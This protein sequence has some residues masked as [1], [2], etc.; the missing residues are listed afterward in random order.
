MTS[1]PPGSYISVFLVFVILAFTVVEC[2]LQM[3]NEILKLMQER[4]ELNLR[5]PTWNN[6]GT[7]IGNQQ[8]HHFL[9][10]SLAYFED[11][12]TIDQSGS[13][14]RLITSPRYDTFLPDFHHGISDV[15]VYTSGI[16][17]RGRET[18][19]I[20]EYLRE[21]VVITSLLHTKISS[22]PHENTK[23]PIYRKISSVSTLADDILFITTSNENY[24][25]NDLF[26]IK[27]DLS[28]KQ[29]STNQIAP[30]HQRLMTREIGV[31]GIADTQQT[32]VKINYNDTTFSYKNETTLAGE[33]G[34]LTVRGYYSVGVSLYISFDSDARTTNK[35]QVGVNF[36]DGVLGVEFYYTSP[37][38]ANTRIFTA[39]TFPKELSSLVLGPVG[40]LFSATFDL[41]VQGQFN[42]NDEVIGF[43]KGLQS[44][45]E[46]NVLYNG[47]TNQIVTHSISNYNFTDSGQSTLVGVP[48]SASYYTIGMGPRVRVNISPGVGTASIS[49]S[50]YLTDV[51][52]G[53]ER[54]GSAFPLSHNLEY[55]MD[56]IA[57]SQLFSEE[58]ATQT[59]PLFERELEYASFSGC[60]VKPVL[61]LALA[62]PFPPIPEDGPSVDSE[63]IIEDGGIV[64]E[65][66]TLITVRDTTLTEYFAMVTMTG[67]GVQEC[68]GCRFNVTLSQ[69]TGQDVSQCGPAKSVT[70][71]DQQTPGFIRATGEIKNAYNSTTPITWFLIQVFISENRQSVEYG[72]KWILKSDCHGDCAFDFP[73]E[74]TFNNNEVSISIPIA[75]T[76]EVSAELFT[77]YY[78]NNANSG[79]ALFFLDSSL[80]S[81]YKFSKTITHL[82]VQIDAYASG[83]STKI[84]T[85]R[86]QNSFLPEF[87]DSFYKITTY[88]FSIASLLQDSNDKDLYITVEAF[89]ATSFRLYLQTVQ[90]TLGLDVQFDVP[91]PASAIVKTIYKG[92][93]GGNYVFECDSD[94]PAVVLYFT[95]NLNVNAVFDKFATHKAGEITVTKT[96][97]S[98]FSVVVQVGSE[99]N[100]MTFFMAAVNSIAVGKYY[101]LN[102]PSVISVIYYRFPLNSLSNDYFIDTLNS[103]S[104]ILFAMLDLNAGSLP[105]KSY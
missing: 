3:H 75:L 28:L 39:S 81:A 64:V 36:V 72:R 24:E 44:T 7:Q 29:I 65:P 33:F 68:L 6:F 13:H 99:V 89:S 14:L 9:K 49:L 85:E 26:G 95:Q 16:A 4:K 52:E 78:T 76:Y 61:P 105:K 80:L 8:N 48:P 54:C 50:P 90:Q 31:S 93:I 101:I 37:P 91:L 46:G 82:I 88:K 62:N 73:V 40:V 96:T 94:S 10:G 55:G 70:L 71:S 92:S 67:T 69:C 47:I 1:H 97:G 100:D 38:V 5:R 41:F 63:V 57:T 86:F 98:T 53:A 60:V 87:Y 77:R 19:S 74:Y 30:E 104:T 51:F 32:S 22:H 21:D 11:V 12:N 58:E 45:F 17:I 35:F 103:P 18:A 59:I 56:L 34:T 20:L 43:G 25:F 84:G 79:Q 66:E 83:T 42:F 15:L 27:F 2:N 102:P 23:E